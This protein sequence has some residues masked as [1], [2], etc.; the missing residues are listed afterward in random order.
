MSIKST[1]MEVSTFFKKEF[2][3]E[4]N[5]P[6]CSQH[7]KFRGFCGARLFGKDLPEKDKNFENPKIGGFDLLINYCPIVVEN[8]FNQKFYGGSCTHGSKQD[9]LHYEKIGKDSGCFV[10]SLNK[11]QKEIP[12]YSEQKTA[13]S[14]EVYS[15]PRIL[16]SR[17]AC[18]EYTCEKG[19]IYLK[20]D[21]KKVHCPSNKITKVP[22]YGGEIK[23]ADKRVMCHKKYKCKFGCTN[24]Q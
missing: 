5:Q 14:L 9:L 18:V 1:V 6:V 19:E 12:P 10:S 23:C 11:E 13:F 20:I 21:D 17:A 16:Q 2:C 7:N 3:E 22:G 24:V 8:K 4:L 15:I